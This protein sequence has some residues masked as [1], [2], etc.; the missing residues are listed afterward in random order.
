M[1]HDVDFA[2]SDSDSRRFLAMVR[3]NRINDV[4][5]ERLPELDLPDC[6][7]VAGC[8]FQT[9][10]NCLSGKRPDEDI[11]DYDVFYYDSSDLSWA[12]EDAAIRRVLAVVGDLGVEV[13]V[14]NQAR[15]HLWY[16]QKFGVDC[17]PLRSARDGI[18]HFLN[19]SSCFG[20]R[21]RAGAAEVYAPYG[22]AD[23]FSM[24]VRPNCRRA[25]PEVYY[26]KARRWA[27]A[28]PNLQVIAWPG[29]PEHSSR[30]VA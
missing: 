24:T 23:L 26:R 16:G 18:D 8:L 5:L 4:L 6:H 30:G 13:Q 21:C 22:F 15:V 25:L 7:L 1:I 9:V 29:V 17:S 10:W 2:V 3:R 12:A 19:R 11:V 28:W 14:R 27:E 20:L